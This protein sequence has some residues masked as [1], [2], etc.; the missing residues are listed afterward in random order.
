MEINITLQL[1]WNATTSFVNPPKT[2]YTSDW[3][4]HNSLPANTTWMLSRILT[5]KP[6]HPT[7]HDLCLTSIHSKAL[8]FHPLFPLPQLFH[9]Q[10]LRFCHQ[11]E[12]ICIKQITDPFPTSTISQKFS[13]VYS[14]SVSIPMF[15]HL[16]TLMPCNLH[17]INHILQKLLSIIRLIVSTGLL[18]RVNLRYSS[19]LI[20]VQP[21]IP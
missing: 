20:W 14:Y 13:N 11:N 7:L 16:Q 3:V 1:S 18:I 15:Q 12:I 21:L 10:F 5:L 19:H 8:C 2:L 9:Q 4:A 17:T 6:A